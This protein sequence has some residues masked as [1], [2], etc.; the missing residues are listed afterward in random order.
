MGLRV[1]YVEA[2]EGGDALFSEHR[3]LVA[4]PQ[5]PEHVAAACFVTGAGLCEVAGAD[6]LFCIVEPLL[7][8]LWTFGGVDRVEFAFRSEGDAAVEQQVAVEHLVEASVVE[9]EAG[10]RLQYLALLELLF[11]ALHDL[12]FFVRELVG[13]LG[14]HSREEIRIERVYFAAYGY[15]VV[16][17]VYLVEE[18]HGVHLVVD[19]PFDE[20]AFQLELHHCSGM[21]HGV[22]E[23]PVVL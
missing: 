11:K 2:L 13:I 15:G 5:V 21:H 7:A 3:A 1:V 8:L 17:K 22:L 4:A 18:E 9:E 10:L 19:M 6:E 20:L 12:F 14:I 23:L 16:V